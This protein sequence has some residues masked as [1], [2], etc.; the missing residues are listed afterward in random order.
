MPMTEDKWARWLNKDRWPEQK[1][2]LEA[3]LNSVR[4]HILELG[5]LKPGQRVL[6][7]GAG[8]G[9]LGLRAAEIVGQTGG[10]TFLDIS[11]G[12]L[13]TAAA[14]PPAGCEHFLVADGIHLPLLDDWADAVV[15][16]SVLIYIQDRRAAANEIARVLRHGG[17]FVAYEPINRRMEQI[18]DM[19][20]FE[21]VEQAYTSAMET[22]PLT[23]FDEND[24][25]GAF[26]EAGFSPV[27][28]ETGESRFPVR[29]KEWVHGFK[30]GAP[31][32]YSGYDMLLAGGIS[33]GRADEFL[34]V[35]ERQI[36]DEW[37]A[38][39]CPHVYITAVR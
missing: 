34:A 9:L 12:A 8:T 3:A 27:E 15:A 36:G 24:L 16:R 38:W 39:S 30:H 14:A 1:A 10:V 23:D 2:P 33:A 22:N 28:I 29:G 21:D 7:L 4:D 19:T 13:K 32:G 17:R 18:I 25:V 11:A 31:A 6:D 35:G 26:R 20:G 5:E 37:R